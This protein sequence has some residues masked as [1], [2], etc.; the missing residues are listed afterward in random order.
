MESKLVSIEFIPDHPKLMR[1]PSVSRSLHH[2]ILPRACQK[3]YENPRIYIFSHPVKIV[4][5]RPNLSE[6]R[7][8]PRSPK[9]LNIGLPASKRPIGGSYIYQ[10]LFNKPIS[11]PKYVPPLKGLKK[12]SPQR[13]KRNVSYYCEVLPPIKS[14]QRDNMQ[15]ENH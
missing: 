11:P 9:P 13:Q 8:T 2:A 4:Y 7:K 6:R 3:M 12:S 10:K 1:L 5:G 14:D 15:T